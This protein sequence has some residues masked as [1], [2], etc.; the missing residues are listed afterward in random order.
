M[1]AAETF[2]DLM[3]SPGHWYFEIFLNLLVDG[4]L[5]WFLWGKIIKPHI[6]RDVEHIGHDHDLHEEHGASESED[7]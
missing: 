5:I 1:L 4:L 7:A 6:H 3:K 2:W